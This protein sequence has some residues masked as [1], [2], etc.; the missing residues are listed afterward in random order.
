M[1]Q[2][3]ASSQVFTGPNRELALLAPH[4]SSVML[5]DALIAIQAFTDERAR[6]CALEALAPY[7]PDKILSQTLTMAQAV[8]DDGWRIRALGALLPYVSYPQQCTIAAHALD[9][10]RSI[11]PTEQSSQAWMLCIIVPYLPLKERPVALQEAL[12]SIRAFPDEFIRVRRIEQLIPYLSPECQLLVLQEAL[13]A[14]YMIEPEYN[15]TNALARILPHLSA[16]LLDKAQCIALD[17]R[18]TG[19]RA[20][21]LAKVALYLPAVQQPDAI[22]T[23]LQCARS[24]VD[25]D[26]CTHFLIQ[27]GA[28]LPLQHH[29]SS[30]AKVIAKASILEGAEETNIPSM[31]PRL[32]H[33]LEFDELPIEWEDILA[34]ACAMGGGYWGEVWRTTSLKEI[35][36]HLFHLDVHR[37]QRLL[38]TTLPVLAGRGR[39]A[40][41]QD[42]AALTPWLEA[43]AT[44]DDLADIAQSI[45][46]VSRCWP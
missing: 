8:L 1:Q 3:L 2:T 38:A 29:V 11:I 6:T 33:S 15:R 41:L 30:Q 45:V 19:C 27:L 43:L 16:P 25:E 14:I 32:V 31:L 42:L 37:Q 39:P 21:A 5:V 24:I 28:H 13:D 18:N 40:F 34:A 35:A 10:M 4:L 20:A 17:I 7:L 22:A 46:D 9:T 36:P 44:P 23:A 26:V 12:D